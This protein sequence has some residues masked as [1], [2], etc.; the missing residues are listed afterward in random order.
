MEYKKS[1]KRSYRR[2]L[3]NKIAKKRQKN[4][5]TKEYNNLNFN[6]N[7]NWWQH[8]GRFRKNTYSCNCSLC[9]WHEKYSNNSKHYIKP[10]YWRLKE[11]NDEINNINYNI[12][13]YKNKPKRYKYELIK[14]KNFKKDKSLIP[15]GL[16]CCNGDY[17]CPYWYGKEYNEDG[18]LRIGGCAYLDDYDYKTFPGCSLLWDQVKE[19][20]ISVTDHEKEELDY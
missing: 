18:W 1:L 8:K 7:D 6:P 16:Y 5:I 10:K 19:C 2:H 12:T 17:K 20:G 11:D 14:L 13:D 4:Y 9:T 3:T 15:V